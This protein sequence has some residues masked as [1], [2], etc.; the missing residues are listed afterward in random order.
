MSTGKLWK[1]RIRQYGNSSDCLIA[2]LNAIETSCVMTREAVHSD[3][4]WL[5]LLSHTTLLVPLD[6]PGILQ[7]MIPACNFICMLARYLASKKPRDTSCTCYFIQD[8]GQKT[9][10]PL[11]SNELSYLCV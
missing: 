9:R 10:W 11:K 5:Y 8:G 4:Y 2:C 7:K 1:F 6:R 3:G